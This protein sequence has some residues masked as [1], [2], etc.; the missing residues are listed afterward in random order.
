MHERQEE[1]ADARSFADRARAV[2]AAGLQAWART[3]TGQPR[4][5]STVDGYRLV[6]SDGSQYIDWMMAWGSCLLGYGHPRVTAAVVD[7]AARGALCSLPHMLEVEVAE[8]L[9]DMLPHAEQV[10][11]GKNGSDVCAAAVRL[12]RAVTGKEGV[13]HF[14]YH[15]FHDWSVAGNGNAEG[16]PAALQKLLFGIAYNDL[17]G[18]ASILDAHAHRVAALI[19]EPMRDVTPL[20]GYLEGVRALTRRYDVVLIFD[21]MVTGFRLH[22]G[23]AALRFGVEP[24]LACYGKALSNGHALAA[25]VGRAAL[26]KALPRVAYGMTARGETIA[27]AAAKAA[28]EVHATVD[29]CGHIAR[30]GAALAERFADV[31]RSVGVQAALRG[32]PAMLTF[33]F[34]GDEAS[35]AVFVE[36]CNAH[37]L[38]THGHVLPSLAH[39]EAAIE[40]SV[41]AFEAGLRAVRQRT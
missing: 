12:A 18:L 23:G 9:R 4:I 15:G 16:V 26:M 5:A 27:L 11:F 37:G 34:G 24:D 22:R 30:I 3:A 40:A 1:A 17:D 41:P 38:L 6:D 8:A 32:D 14:G 36:T 13:L 29:V 31:A 2:L 10:A 25:L 7:Q 33:D 39:D 35:R 19:L 20:P 21:E 28:L